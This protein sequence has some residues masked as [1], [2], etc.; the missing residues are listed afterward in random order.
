MV[1]CIQDTGTTTV[2]LFNKET[3]QLIGVPTQ[4]LM[5]ELGEVS[6]IDTVLATN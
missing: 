1:A 3:E 5:T 2:T 6:M 4:N